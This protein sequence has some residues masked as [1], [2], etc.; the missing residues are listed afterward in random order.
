MEAE[1]GLRL[2]FSFF[3]DVAWVDPWH[4]TIVGV[5]LG[6]ALLQWIIILYQAKSSGV[7]VEIRPTEFPQRYIPASPKLRVLPMAKDI[8]F[9]LWNLLPFVFLAC[10]VFAAYRWDEW[11]TELSLGFG[12]FGDWQVPWFLSGYVWLPLGSL[13]GIVGCAGQLGK[14]KDTH[15]LYWW[16][17]ELRPRIFVVRFV[18]LFFNMFTVT[19][20]VGFILRLGYV[21]TAAAFGHDIQPTF[22]HPDGAAGFGSLGQAALAL[23]MTCLV[24]SGFAVVAWVDHR[25]QGSLHRAGDVVL[26]LVPLVLGLWIVLGPPLKVDRAL[27]AEWLPLHRTALGAGAGLAGAAE[28]AAGADWLDVRGPFLIRPAF[29]LDVRTI[30]SLLFSLLAPVALYGLRYYAGY[31]APRLFARVEQDE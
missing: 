9:I 18:A 31:L 27:M 12:G 26:L 20:G 3:D 28:G 11:A 19:I 22:A 25:G 17:R 8:W 24:V 23:S 16:D 29:P 21:L 1:H 14:H 10:Y 5:L 15:H 13:A 7:L 4:E 2:R 6:V 30:A